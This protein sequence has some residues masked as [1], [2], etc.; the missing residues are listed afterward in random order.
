MTDL[1]DLY[2]NADRLLDLAQNRREL[3]GLRKS[4]DRG[5]EAIKSEQVRQ[6]AK[7]PNAAIA[8]AAYEINRAKDPRR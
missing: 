7:Q 4:I 6:A 3:D 8:S 2:A 5:R 1:N